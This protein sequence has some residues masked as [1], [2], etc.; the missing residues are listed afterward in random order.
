MVDA[1]INTSINTT[2]VYGGYAILKYS[3]SKPAELAS[4]DEL[5]TDAV[6][7]FITPYLPTGDF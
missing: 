1:C 4:Y 3:G 2:P 5:D 6:N 7:T